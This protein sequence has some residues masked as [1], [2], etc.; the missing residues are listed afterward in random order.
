LRLRAVMNAVRAAALFGAAA[1][2][3]ACAEK[4]AGAV[5]SEP[6]SAQSKTEAL[7][8]TLAGIDRGRRNAIV[9][10]SERVEPAVVTVSVLRAQLVERPVFQDEFFFP[11]RGMRQRFWQRVQGL[12]SGVIVGR[13]GTII[14]N[15]HVVKGA[16][17]IKITLPDGREFG[18]KYL[19]GTELYDLA[20]LEMEIDGAEIPIAP[21]GDSK[22]L[23]IGEWAIAIGNPFGY[24]LDDTEPTVTVGVISAT[25][26]DVM[27]E[28]NRV[29]IYKDMIQTD[30]AINPGNSGG[31]LVNALGEVIG[32][33]TFIL[34]RSGGSQGIGFAI[35]ID[36]VRRVVAEIK[37]HGQVREVW[38]GVQV[39]E[40]PASLAES[41]E[42]DSTAGVIV[43]SV[44]R[45]SPAEKAGIRRGDVIRKI[46]DNTIADFEDAK[47][48]LY[49]MMVD[50]VIDFVIQRGN[51]KPETAT[52]RLVERSE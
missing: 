22:D 14:T 3:C 44:D 12:G 8:T 4:R 20:V 38:V 31:P 30:A 40:I 19:G 23:M 34:S 39:Q 47:R 45:G 42:L 36:T 7:D 17:T 2:A 35:P 11:F 6:P 18:A 9:V 51:A 26:R 25:S 21:L 13:D 48:A 41:L 15:F 52:L 37:A 50:D 1:L 16:Q 5:D 43:A 46:G 32:I 24:L 33:N 49:G 28:T 10:A 27:I 29:T